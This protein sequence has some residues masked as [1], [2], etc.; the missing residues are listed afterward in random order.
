MS[1]DYM[2][3]DR[4]V[5]DALRGVVRRA[6]IEAAANGLNGNHHFYLTFRTLAPGVQIP[7]YL[8]ER[9][10][11]EMTI[12]LQFQFYGLEV[13]DD[14]FTVTLSF[15]N[16]QERLTIPYNAITIFADPSVNFALQFQQADEA[17][18]ES[19]GA[20]QVAALEGPKPATGK[21]V[22]AKGDGEDK[23]GEVVSLDQFRRK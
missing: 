15:N 9:Y 5:E 2:R 23:T 1:K 4:M 16:Q 11:D 3:Y 7:A 19:G 8:V 17:G 13:G 21:P 18:E 22:A 20:E 10:P 14:L 6:L 12:V